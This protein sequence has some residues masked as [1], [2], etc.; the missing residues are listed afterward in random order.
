LNWE[1]KNHTEIDTKTGLNEPVFILGVAILKSK[2]LD[3]QAEFFLRPSSP[4]IADTRSRLSSLQ[5][6]LFNI[7]GEHCDLEVH[8]LLSGN[9]TSRLSSPLQSS[10]PP[11]V[12][13]SSSR[14]S[15]TY[16]HHHLHPHHGAHPVPHRR[17]P[18]KTGLLCVQPGPGNNSIDPAWPYTMDTDTGDRA[19]SPISI[20]RFS[21]TP[22]YNTP[23]PQCCFFCLR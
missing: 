20:L 18:H 8:H 16:S 21:F 14:L 5:S 15:S 12:E 2:C 23:G 6:P 10:S 22:I 7:Y 3:G 11:T 17:E 1:V 4:P 9:T 19:P 13:N